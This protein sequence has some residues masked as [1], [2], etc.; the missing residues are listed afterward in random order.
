MESEEEEEGAAAA[1]FASW[2][3]YENREVLAR[4]AVLDPIGSG[5]YS[6]VYHGKRRDDGLHVALKEVHDGKSSSR[7]LAALQLL[8][9]SSHVVQLLDH[10]WLHPGVLLVLE[11]L[12][13]SLAEVIEERKE[14]P[15]Q[16]FEARNW[17][18]QILKAVAECHSAGI[19]HR[20]L[21]PSNLLISSDGVLKVADFGTA[22]VLPVENVEEAVKDSS[23][24]KK[25]LKGGE[26]FDRFGSGKKLDSEE[27]EAWLQGGSFKL[28]SAATSSEQQPETMVPAQI[29]GSKSYDRLEIEDS[30]TEVSPRVSDAE[31]EEDGARSRNDRYSDGEWEKTSNKDSDW[32]KVGNDDFRGEMTDCVGTRWYKAP[33][34]LYGSTSYNFAVDLWAVGCILGELIQGEP[35]FPGASD[36][37]QLSR[38]VRVLGVPNE[39]IWPGIS[40]LPDYDKIC[41]NDD[42]PPVTLARILPRASGE[43]LRLI[44]KLLVYDP[45]SR[46]SASQALSHEFFSGRASSIDAWL[47]AGS[48]K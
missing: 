39:T 33:E 42:R 32:Y 43:A 19:L 38:V 30:G 25:K 16:E 8:T 9:N 41:F 46:L 48:R 23:S 3:I 44:E 1:K 18:E 20:D 40:S 5:A 27:I 6:D 10:V 7:E 28:K 21:K 17:M 45:A 11:F 4:Y 26:E 22:L 47:N 13:G 35:L 36:I 37:D 31:E 34:L 29:R 12:P 15:F 2:S 24:G 14:I